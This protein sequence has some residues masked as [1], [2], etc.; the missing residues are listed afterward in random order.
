MFFLKKYS[1]RKA[2]S[3]IKFIGNQRY[4]SMY[5][6]PRDN[7]RPLQNAHYCSSSRKMKILYRDDFELGGKEKDLWKK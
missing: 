4:C 2:V 5:N 7:L 3:H 1:T 6:Y